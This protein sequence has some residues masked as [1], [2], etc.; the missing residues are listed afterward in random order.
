MIRFSQ[1]HGALALVIFCAACGS[2]PTDTV[3]DQPLDEKEQEITADPAKA[4]EAPR[5]DRKHDRKHDKGHGGPAMLLRAALGELTL[6]ADQKQKIEGLLAELKDAGPGRGAEGRALEK[7]IANSVR[8][9]SFDDAVFQKHYAAVETEAKAH[10]EKTQRALGTLHATLT[11]EQRS[12]LVTALE[13]RTKDG[14]RDHA[15]KG[16][17]GFGFDKGL[18]DLDLSDEQRQ[19]LESARADKPDFE[20]LGDW[21]AKKAE[22]LSAFES[23]DFDAKKLVNAGE[24]ARHARGFAE[25]RV[26]RA[27]TLSEIL[28]PEQRTKYAAS[29]ETRSH[30]EKH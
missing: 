22:L 30:G 10:A 13:T 24:M 4:A 20:K 28:T 15:K 5:V 17:R 8:S 2:G 12:Q 6:A 1:N 26:K 27:R 25:M 7:S 9:G 29:L 19:K 3:P 23:A 14:K 16:R 18:R 11:P 21:K